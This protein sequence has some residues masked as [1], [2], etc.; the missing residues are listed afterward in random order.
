LRESDRRRQAVRPRAD[1]DRI[2]LRHVAS[3]LYS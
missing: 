1:H 2:R 3:D